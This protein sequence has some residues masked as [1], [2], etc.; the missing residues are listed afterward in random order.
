MELIKYLLYNYGMRNILALTFSFLL[1]FS[2]T[3]TNQKSVAKSSFDSD[4]IKIV[5]KMSVREKIGQVFLINFRFFDVNEWNF[6]HGDLIEYEDINGKKYNVVAVDRLNSTITTAIK[7]YHI[8]N[9]ILFAENFNSTK[10][11]VNLISRMQ[12]AATSSG[13]LPLIIS[14]DQEGGRVNRFFQTTVYPPAAVIG[15]TKKPEL[16]FTEGQYLA[17]QCTA[18]GIN[19]DFAPVCDVNSNPKNPVIG[20]RSFSSVP[21]TAALFSAE[22]SKGLSSK[23]VISCAK[24]F[25]GHGDTDTDSHLGLPVIRKSKSQWNS[26]EAVPFKKIISENIPVIM[27]AHIQYPALDSSKI[28]AQKTGRMIVRPA[29]LSKKILT[30]LLRG[31]LGFE[32]VIC[33]D[34]LDMRAI[35]KNFT[36]SQAVIEA[37]NAGADMLCNPIQIISQKDI[38][39][40]E[41][42]YQKIELAIK[43][44]S[45]SEAR[46]TEAAM[47]IVQLKKDYGILSAIYSLPTKEDISNTQKILSDKKYANFKNSIIK[48]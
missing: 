12:L 2:C 42:L 39:R 11:A 27:S 41:D 32:G 24:H 38:S 22:L 15:M 30:D 1:L 14:V 21:K 18:F 8:G 19:L 7:K 9:V 3:S 28:K 23:N 37:L 4:V 31:E 36:E 33:T 40:L 43:D 34:A 45:L 48:K 26:C 20:D 6:P 35:S 46:L 13:N 25:P 16:A 5:N 10:S 29:T 47:R 44:G 17:E